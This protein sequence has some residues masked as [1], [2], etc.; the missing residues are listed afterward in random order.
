MN[1]TDFAGMLCSRLCHDLVSPVG[2]IN[3]GI[4]LLLDKN[5]ADMQEQIVELIRD[6]AL[7]TKN[8]LQFFRLAFG[9][10]GGFGSAISVDEA[11]QALS[12]VFDPERITISWTSN[13]Q[14]LSKEVMKVIMNI[15]L[16]AGEAIIGN[17]TLDIKISDADG[18]FDH[19]EMKIS[20]S[21]IIL[22]DAVVDLFAEDELSNLEPKAIPVAMA[23]LIS[24]D[25]GLMLEIAK[26]E[27]EV[28]VFVLSS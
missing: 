18:V 14:E 8:K 11:T 12:G 7:Q 26:H 5:N 13:L 28:V 15:A 1:K 6:S 23:K 16:I 27:E 20:S 19:A 17:G 3:N 25:T 2:A 4:E 24:R 9:I 10:G 21:R 22:Q